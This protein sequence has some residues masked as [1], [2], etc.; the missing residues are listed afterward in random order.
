MSNPSET[1]LI[2][3]VQAVFVLSVH[4]YLAVWDVNPFTGALSAVS[5]KID[6]KVQQLCHLEWST[7]QARMLFW[8]R[9]RRLVSPKMNTIFLVDTNGAN[10]IEVS[11]DKN[12]GSSIVAQY[13]LGNTSFP[14]DATVISVKGGEYLYVN[15]PGQNTILVFL[16][17]APRKATLVQKLAL[18]APLEQ[19]R[20]T[21]G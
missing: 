5:K 12:L 6:I 3:T 18:G 7:F 8:R 16:V 11:V 4:G 9:I 21:A 2:L 10:V 17:P 1:Q 15:D 19:L 14:I 13:S 20:V